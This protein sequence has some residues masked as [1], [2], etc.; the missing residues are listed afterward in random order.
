MSPQETR[1]AESRWAL[2]A[3][4]AT[5]LGVALLVI[6][7]FVDVGGSE[8]PE[9]LRN[10]HAHPGSVTL[11]A[12]LQ[13]FGLLLLTIPLLYLFRA[14]RARSPQV[15]SRLLGL[16]IA[17]P[18]FLAISSGLSIGVRQEAADQFVA[19]EAKSTLSKQEAREEC[20]SDRK[21]EGKKDFAEEFE[22]E[23]GETPLAACERQKR[24]VDK[25]SNALGEASLTPLATGLG[26][27]GALG[28]V[29]T[30]FYTCLWGMRTGLLNRFWGSLGMASGIAF[31]LGPLSFIALLWFAYFG[32]LLAGLVPGGRPP[33]WEAG[34]AVPWPTPG[35]RAAAELE[36]SESEEAGSEGAVEKRKRKQRE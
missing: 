30:L 6:S 20:T 13:T 16:V 28:L 35:E 22:P 7:R 26:L 9:I 12:L 21:D 3:A 11:A 23:K 1:E 17:A 14:V 33:A 4:L 36:P 34:E 29:V 31:L 8:N 15:R 10:V 24:E 18:L 5:F 32:L 27:A 25:A 2:P 19:G